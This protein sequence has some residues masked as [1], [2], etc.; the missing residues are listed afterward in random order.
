MNFKHQKKCPHQSVPLCG[1]VY[2]YFESLESRFR[3]ADELAKA[4][5]DVNGR[6]L[7]SNWAWDQTIK[8]LEAYEKSSKV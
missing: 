1:C 6:K 2:S 3:A 7:W 4:V 5:A 8:K